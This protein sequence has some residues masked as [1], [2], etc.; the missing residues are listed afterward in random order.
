M[1]R[2]VARMQFL[3]SARARAARDIALKLQMIGPGASLVIR[4]WGGYNRREEP[5]LEPLG[6]QRA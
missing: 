3:T 6:S 1:S 4:Q 2:V 5:Y